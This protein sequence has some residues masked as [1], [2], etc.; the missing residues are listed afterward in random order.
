MKNKEQKSLN[1]VED[2][3]DI[4]KLCAMMMHSLDRIEDLLTK[5]TQIA[6]NIDKIAN[7]AEWIEQSL[8]ELEKR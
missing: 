1:W 2:V 6:D 3:N 5:L 4:N 7:H 8:H